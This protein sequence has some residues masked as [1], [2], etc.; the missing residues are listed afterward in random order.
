MRG[1]A[2]FDVFAGDENRPIWR[3]TFNDLD[4][5]KALAKKL[6]SQEGLE[7]F[8][9]NFEDQQEVAHFFPPKPSGS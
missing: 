8:V 9:F 4:S 3:G 1:D 5:A 7:F 2:H 6:A